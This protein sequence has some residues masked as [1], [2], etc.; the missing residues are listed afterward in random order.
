MA[1]GILGEGFMN[2]KEDGK[3]NEY[4]DVGK[5]REP[6]LVGLGCFFPSRRFFLLIYIPIRHS[7]N[8][9]CM[10]IR[11]SFHHLGTLKLALHSSVE[12]DYNKHDI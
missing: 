8:R 3:D 7:N 4:A 1:L 2:V 5:L 10:R 6:R 9:T 12:S 11:F